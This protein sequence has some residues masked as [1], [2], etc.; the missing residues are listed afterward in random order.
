MWLNWTPFRGLAQGTRNDLEGFEQQGFITGRAGDT[1]EFDY[2][3]KHGALLDTVR[4]KDV[5]WVCRLLARLSDT[6]WHDAFRAGGYSRNTASRYIAKLK[7]KIA[8]GL[9]LDGG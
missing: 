6:Q 3:G 5:V 9:A 7:T 2:R 1:I 8:E 4:S